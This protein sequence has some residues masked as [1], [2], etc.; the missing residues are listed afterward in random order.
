VPP[1]NV[2]T[3]SRVIEPARPG[4]SPHHPARRGAAGLPV[5]APRGRPAA[6]ARRVL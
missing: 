3:L 6:P 4:T 2:V 5:A 1:A